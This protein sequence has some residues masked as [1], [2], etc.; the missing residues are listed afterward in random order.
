MMLSFI[1][2]I[3]ACGSNNEETNETKQDSPSDENET[4]E[5][6]TVTDLVGD[7]ITFNEPPKRIIPLSA[8][9]LETIDALGGEAIGRP[10]IRG[11]I[12]EAFEDI[13]EIGTSNEVNLEK[14][15]SLDPDLVIAHPQMNAKEVPALEE[16]GIEVI[17]TGAKN[18]EEIQASIEMFGSIL[19]KEA[20]AKALNENIDEKITALQT[21]EELRTLL[22]FGVP[23]TLMV[24][25]PNTLSGS[26]LDAAGGYNI[27]EDFPE[28]ED[29]PGYAQVDTEKILEADPEAIFLITPG[30]PEQ[31][32]KSLSEEI[33]K[34]PAWKS[35]SA[36]KNDHIVQLP[37][38]LFG[39]NPGAKVIESL[40]YLHDEIESIQKEQ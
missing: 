22:V 23:G 4:A 19:Q 14:I 1:L 8:G 30:P 31:A 20:E 27:S 36:V 37:N 25:L 7:T 15:I 24:A 28:L 11:E 17:H 38:A 10:V 18:I 40:D 33:E 16:M 6:I 5:Q 32:Q 26:M 12:P 9:D 29:Y 3:S 21:D 13:P 34:N 39:A 2:L 35:V